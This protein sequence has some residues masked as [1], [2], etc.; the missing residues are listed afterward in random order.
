MLKGDYV[1]HT[2]IASFETALHDLL[3]IRCDLRR[4]ASLQYKVCQG[5]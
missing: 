2:E 1:E 4:G 3:K 5:S